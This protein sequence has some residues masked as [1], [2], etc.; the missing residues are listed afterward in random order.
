MFNQRNE[1]M[2]VMIDE[3]IWLQVFEMFSLDG[4]T[5]M[6][7]YLVKWFQDNFDGLEDL[8]E[9]TTFDNAEFAYI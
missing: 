8:S 4:W 5:E 7:D 6:N 1:A 3:S 9:V 2:E